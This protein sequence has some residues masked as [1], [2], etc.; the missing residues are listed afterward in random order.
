LMVAQRAGSWPF[1]QTN[2]AFTDRSAFRSC[3]KG[4]KT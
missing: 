4:G 2:Y 1:S 3:S